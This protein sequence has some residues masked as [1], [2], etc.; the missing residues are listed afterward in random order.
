MY[1]IYK[2]TNLVNG[3]FYIGKHLQKIDPYVFD[4]YFGSGTQIK[5]AIKKYGKEK[6]IR[7]TLAVFDDEKDCLNEEQILISKF[8]G[9][10]FCYNMKEGGIGGFGHINNNPQL[11]EK[12][13]QL[14][15]EKNKGKCRH[16]P[17]PAERKASSERNKRNKELLLGAYSEEAMQKRREASKKNGGPS[18]ERNGMF[19]SKVYI[20][21]KTKEKRRYLP[22][23][24]IPKGWIPSLEYQE[25]KKKKFWYNDTKTEYLLDPKDNKI[26]EKGLLRG[27]L[28]RNQ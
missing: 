10:P 22:G 2:T 25:T 21:L 4:G 19:G 27:R 24:N 26:Y 14:S 6:F 8:L 3:K 12:V 7:E 18:G 15:R 28:Y 20:N 13:T 5:S 17:T 16:I 23:E 11:R 1:I 9:D